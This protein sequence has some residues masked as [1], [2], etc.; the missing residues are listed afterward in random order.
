MRLKCVLAWLKSGRLRC[1][2][3]VYRSCNQSVREGLNFA[4]MMNSR[5]SFEGIALLEEVHVGMAA[6]PEGLVALWLE[7]LISFHKR[8]CFRNLTI[9]KS[10][11]RRNFG[12]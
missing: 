3:H 12:A 11:T 1:E 8:T 6:L 4:P 9:S 5:F 7:M 10:C 2:A